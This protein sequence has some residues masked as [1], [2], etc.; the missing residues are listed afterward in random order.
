MFY[1]FMGFA[2]VWLF[3]TG[4]IIYLGWRQRQIEADMRMLQEEVQAKQK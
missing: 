1:L 3:V 4:Y 2:A